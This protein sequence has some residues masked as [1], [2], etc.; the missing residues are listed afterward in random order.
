MCIT[1]KRISM[2]SVTK[3]EKVKN[4]MK[5]EE[6]LAQQ[7][8]MPFVE[9]VRKV[10]HKTIRCWIQLGKVF[11]S[12]RDQLSDEYWKKFKKEV[13]YSETDISRYRT[14]AQNEWLLEHEKEMP[15]N[16]SAIYELL[17]ID[18]RALLDD[19]IK[20]GRIH[21]KMR[22]KDAVALR[23][24]V[25]TG[26]SPVDCLQFAVVSASEKAT[27]DELESLQ[28]ELQRLQ[29]DY[30]A[31]QVKIVADE[32]KRIVFAPDTKSAD[33]VVQKAQKKPAQYHTPTFESFVKM[34]EAFKSAS[35]KDEKADAWKSIAQLRKKEVA[36]DV[37]SKKKNQ[38][39]QTDKQTL[40]D[41]I[42]ALL[43]RKVKPEVQVAA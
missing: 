33:K 30:P 9:Q 38:I 5:T 4:T 28:N 31:M 20:D 36:Y 41:T 10:E 6:Q 23:Q 19:A 17:K 1:F 13:D 21:P 8:I 25:L 27:A 7:K 34:Y 18:E 29:A 15:K 12:A 16:Y 37:E 11:E 32:G 39:L 22:T 35:T 2:S 24:Q 14:I 43:G 40:E 3:V 42:R 26:K